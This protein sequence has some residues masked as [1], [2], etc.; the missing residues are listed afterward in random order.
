MRLGYTTPAC[1][2]AFTSEEL[3]ST[4][5]FL[6]NLRAAVNAGLPEQAALEALTVTPATFLGLDTSL[7]TLDPGKAANVVAVDGN[8][9]DDGRVR[10]HVDR[11]PALREH[12]GTE[13]NRGGESRRRH[14]L[15]HPVRT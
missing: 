9:F 10:R 13:E 5:K 6:P 1:D 12:G 2:F 8:L 14:R 11:W 7:G 15:L 4:V 3:E